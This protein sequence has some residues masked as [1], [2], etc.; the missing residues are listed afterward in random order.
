MEEGLPAPE[1]RELYA[2]IEEFEAH[3]TQLAR[4][5]G[6]VFTKLKGSCVGSDISP[7][8]VDACKPPV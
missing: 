1:W 3:A 7:S 5:H 6:Q 8:A 4:T 2:S